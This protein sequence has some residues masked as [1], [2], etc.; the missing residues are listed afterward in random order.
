MRQWRWPGF[1]QA[2]GVMYISCRESGEAKHPQ[3]KLNK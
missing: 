2:N 1:H 3:K